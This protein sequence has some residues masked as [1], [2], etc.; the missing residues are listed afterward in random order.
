[1][2]VFHELMVKGEYAAET[3]RRLSQAE[4]ALAYTGGY[5]LEELGSKLETCLALLFE[6]CGT[7][8][9]ASNSKYL[10]A[11]YVKVI[12][13]VRRKAGFR[14]VYKTDKEFKNCF[15]KM[16]D[17]V[18]KAYNKRKMSPH[19]FIANKGCDKDVYL[20]ASL[21]SFLEENGFALE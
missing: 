14:D 16:Q 11:K 9:A 15:N 1:M 20:L 2:G 18:I 13:G 17:K 6:S 7:S 12:G 3:T 10:S 4:N 5:D 8:W 21:M 19:P